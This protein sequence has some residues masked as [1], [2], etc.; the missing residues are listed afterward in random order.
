VV[1]SAEPA[2]AQP[3]PHAATARGR[4][5]AFESL[6]VTNFRYLLG[7]T[8]TSSFATWME[9]IG[10]GWLVAQLTDSAFQLG[11]VQFPWH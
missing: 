7:G 1:E 4:S 11:L 9:Q 8:A 6:S 5:S 3:I 2:D 10:Q